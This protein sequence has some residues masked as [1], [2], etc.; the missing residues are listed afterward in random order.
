MIFSKKQNEAKK[1]FFFFVKLTNLKE[2]KE[3]EKKRKKYYFDF[4]YFKINFMKC[5]PRFLVKRDFDGNERLP[6]V[7]KTHNPCSAN[8]V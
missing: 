1:F 8:G 2:K 4:L 7:R 5:F 3:K 6:A